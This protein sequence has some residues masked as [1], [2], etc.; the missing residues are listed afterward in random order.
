VDDAADARRLL[1]F[2]V[3]R[4]YGPRMRVGIIG[5][6]DV[7]TILANGFAS[8]GHDVVVGTRDPQGPKAKATQGKVGKA[9]VASMAEAAR[10]GEVLVFAVHGANVEEAVREA[11]PDH[12]AGKLVLDTTNPL[13]FG[14]KGAH[15]PAN[16]P[17]SCLQVAQRAA[18]G[19]RF[20]KAWNCTPG[21]SMV[22]PA[23][24]GGGDQLICGDD[25]KA[26]EQAARILQEFGWRVADV[27]DASM[28]PY[29]EGAALAVINWAAKSG[30]WNWVVGLNGRKS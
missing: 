24:P 13:E 15:K 20:V 9:R 4:C 28:A 19:A 26:K 21:H 16:I 18:P 5:S 23:Q 22:D 1:R 11:G 30:D 10:H 2:F 12:M 14:P 6:G 25:P 8:K 7:G 3:P 17:D 29:V 27:G